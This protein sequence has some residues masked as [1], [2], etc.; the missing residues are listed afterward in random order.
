MNR[1][2]F[3]NRINKGDIP[4]GRILIE[5]NV[6]NIPQRLKEIEKGLFVVLNVITQHYELHNEEQEHSTY[7]LTFPFEQLDSRA[8]DL[9]MERLSHRGENILLE[10]DRHNKAVEKSNEKRADDGYDQILREH[11]KFAHIRGKGIVVN[12]QKEVLA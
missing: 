2:E 3:E 10:I 12:K 7:C 6:F 1:S 4:R 11:F 8:I 9:T 5:D